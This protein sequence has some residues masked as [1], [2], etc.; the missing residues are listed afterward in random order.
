M[1]L[2]DPAHVA[3]AKVLREQLNDRQPRSLPT[4]IWVGTWPTTTARSA[5]SAGP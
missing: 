1:T 2:T 4:T 5:S 3:A